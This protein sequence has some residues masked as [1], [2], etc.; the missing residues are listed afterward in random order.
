MSE[1]Q[2]ETVAATAESIL[3]KVERGRVALQQ[4]DSQN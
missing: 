2:R 4:V 1:G 3:T